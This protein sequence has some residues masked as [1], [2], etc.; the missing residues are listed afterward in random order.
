[1]PLKIFAPTIAAIILF[2]DDELAEQYC[3]AINDVR[4][5]KVCS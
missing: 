2:D 1:M 3:N 5:S 4:P